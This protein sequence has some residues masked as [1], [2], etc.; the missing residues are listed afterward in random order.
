[1][2]SEFRVAYL[3]YVGVRVGGLAIGIDYQS[4]IYWGRVISIC[5]QGLVTLQY[6][7][8]EGVGHKTVELHPYRC[9]GDPYEERQ[10]IN[11]HLHTRESVLVYF[12]HYVIPKLKAFPEYYA[13]IQRLNASIMGP[14]EYI[15]R[16]DP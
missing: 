7:A 15:Y 5:D 16:E 2:K 13:E 6:Y 9:I 11:G 8:G 12:H 14:S 10:P 1:M 3:Q 4:T